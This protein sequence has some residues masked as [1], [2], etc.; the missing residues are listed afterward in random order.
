M[1]SRRDRRVVVQVNDKVHHVL[2]PHEHR[3]ANA[4]ATAGSALATAS[5]STAAAGAAASTATPVASAAAAAAPSTAAGSV[6]VQQG[7]GH[8]VL[9]NVERDVGVATKT[10]DRSTKPLI[11]DVWKLDAKESAAVRL[12]FSF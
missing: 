10:I 2:H 6:V 9:D 7:G 11:D 8:T 1:S 3:G 12:I 5:A 4:N